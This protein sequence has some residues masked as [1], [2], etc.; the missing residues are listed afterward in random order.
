[1]ISIKSDTDIAGIRDAGRI[2]ASALRKV[3]ESVR[4]GISTL[5][6]NAI[7]ENSIKGDGGRPAFLHYRGYPATICASVNDCV[8][9]GIPS[10]G[11]LKAGDIISID[12]GVEYRGYYADMAA[13]FA[14]GDIDKGLRQL[15]GV[16]ERSLLNG[17]DMARPGRRL[18]DISSAVQKTAEASGYG[19]VRAFVGHGIGKNLHEEPEIPNYGEAG[20]GEVLRRGMVFA[21]EPM[22][23]AGGSEIY[24]CDDGW[25]A[26]TKDGS[27]SAHF[28]HT[29]AITDS[30]PEILTTE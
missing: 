6:L 28:E 16:T 26:R 10:S 1:M 7:A 4:P 14:V 17:I 13:T 9:H 2:T 8:V 21:I 24:I 23:N 19:V 20:T 30:G 15:I 12:V 18:F 5:E 22:L 3:R 29:V 25:T 11:E 27:M